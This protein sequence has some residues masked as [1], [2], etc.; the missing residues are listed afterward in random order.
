[1]GRDTL[2][3][4]DRVSV[5]ENVWS[6]GGGIGVLKKVE[7]TWCTVLMEETDSPLGSVKDQHWYYNLS[8]V[9]PIDDL[10]EC[11][12]PCPT[13]CEEEVLES[14]TEP[15]PPDMVT[16]ETG[17]IR[18]SKEGKGRPD[19]LLAGFP[20]ALTALS[21]H[22]DCELGRERN[23]EKGL[24]ETGLISSQFRHLLGYVSGVSEDDP[25]YNLVA[26]LWNAAVLLEEYLMVQDGS[27]PSE[28]LDVRR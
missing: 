11:T 1:M 15:T 12:G 13:A 20:R 22:M 24:P 18:E 21:Q 27:M 9:T 3:V 28:V 26:N 6:F 10:P 17:A 4:G 23:W 16:H 14:P 7:D 5:D 2:K 8:E 25:R 19:L